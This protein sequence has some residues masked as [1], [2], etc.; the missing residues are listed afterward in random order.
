[1]EDIVGARNDGRELLVIADINVV[2]GRL[3]VDPVFPLTARIIVYHMDL[4]AT[5]DERRHDM[6]PDKA[7]SACYYCFIFFHIIYEPRAVTNIRTVCSIINKSSKSERC[8]R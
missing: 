1:M 7:C 8:A 3:G 2:V 6:R 4:I 5:L